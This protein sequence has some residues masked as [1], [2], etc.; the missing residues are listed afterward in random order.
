MKNRHQFQQSPHRKMHWIQIRR[1][2]RP[3]LLT[4]E[5]W[6]ITFA[7]V[8]SFSWGVA[9][10]SIL[11]KGETLIFGSVLHLILKI[12]SQNI[13]IKLYLCST[14]TRSYF[15]DLETAVYTMRKKPYLSAVNCSH[16]VINDCYRV[17]VHSIVLIANSRFDCEKSFIR[18]KLSLALACQPSVLQEEYFW[19]FKFLVLLSRF[20][21]FLLSRRQPYIIFEDDS[22]GGHAHIY[23]FSHLACRSLWIPPY[24]FTDSFNHFLWSS[25]AWYPTP[26]TVFRCT[27]FLKSIHNMVHRGF[28][29][30]TFKSLI[31][32]EFV[33]SAHLSWIIAS[34]LLIFWKFN[35]NYFNIIAE[36]D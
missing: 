15:Q 32:S 18:K 25:K 3:H 27:K 28:S 5:S 22:H 34:C 36:N 19:S 33:L 10:C 13:F 30:V 8:L 29:L 23:V 7:P 1:C 6:Q 2:R 21:Y 11:L 17:C 14:K 31:I 12:R 4:P 20:R 24:P 35:E 9:W 16:G 26:R